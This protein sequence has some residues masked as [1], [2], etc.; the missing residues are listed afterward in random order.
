MRFATLVALAVVASTVP[1]L[2]APAPYFASRVA[3]N[4]DNST[5]ESSL[6]NGT[7]HHLNGTDILQHVN[8]TI[9]EIK[10]FWGG[11][12]GLTV[13]GTRTNSSL[14]SKRDNTSDIV[15]A[16]EAVLNELPPTRKRDTTADIAAALQTLLDVSGS[17]PSDVKR[18]SASSDVEDRSLNFSDILSIITTGFQN[19]GSLEGVTKRQPY[20]IPPVEERSLLSPSASSLLKNIANVV[21]IGI[22]AD[23]IANAFGGSDSTKR[24]FA[25]DGDSI[26]LVDERSLL[27]PSASSLLKNIANVVSIGIGADTIANAFGGSDST[28]R[29]LDQTFGGIGG[30]GGILGSEAVQMEERSPAIS[31]SIGNALG[32]LATIAS[33]GGNNGMRRD[34]GMDSGHN[35]DQKRVVSSDIETI[36][37]QIVASFEGAVDPSGSTSASTKRSTGVLGL[38]DI[39]TPEQLEEILNDSYYA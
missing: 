6:C 29:N 5:V 8:D 25:Y 37:Q 11:L 39:M 30:V 36:L 27:S 34:L 1:S 9:P 10:Q 18:D 13:N 22:G 26:T 16:I 35:H 28:K 21:S 32:K 24:D 12:V 14:T 38:T 3:S 17:V 19:A 23:T 33:V 20:S 2:A 15:Q 7:F 31:S 4:L